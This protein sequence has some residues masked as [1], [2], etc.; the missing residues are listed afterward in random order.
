MV[1]HPCVRPTNAREGKPEVTFEL[2]TRCS[3]FPSARQQSH[4]DSCREVSKRAWA[5]DVL[6]TT[7]WLLFWASAKAVS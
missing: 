4:T 3:N 2:L 6:L 5:E 1:R 7:S